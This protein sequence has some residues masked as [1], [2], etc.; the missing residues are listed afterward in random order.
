MRTPVVF[1]LAHVIKAVMLIEFDTSQLKISKQ[2]LN[3]RSPLCKVNQDH[4]PFIDKAMNVQK[5]NCEVVHLYISYLMKQSP[6]PLRDRKLHTL[7]KFQKSRLVRPN[8]S[9]PAYK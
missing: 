7:E 9:M 1:Y 8:K 3:T 2:L 6:S 4:P 5:G